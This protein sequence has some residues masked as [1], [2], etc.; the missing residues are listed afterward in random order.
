MREDGLL[1]T[2]MN[3]SFGRILS[4]NTR[5][6]KIEKISEFPSALDIGSVQKMIFCEHDAGPFWMKPM[7]KITTKYDVEEAGSVTKE[8]NKR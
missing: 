6:T 3:W 4:S 5:N 2:N 8:K 1:I 7:V